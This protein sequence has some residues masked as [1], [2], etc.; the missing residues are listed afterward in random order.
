MA[1]IYCPLLLPGSCFLS[2]QG[3][4]RVC[5]GGAHLA[6]TDEFIY[7]R[8]QRRDGFSPV[9][10]STAGKAPGCNSFAGLVLLPLCCSCCFTPHPAADCGV[11]LKMTAKINRIVH[12]YKTARGYDVGGREEGG[13]EVRTSVSS[14][15]FV[16][17]AS[18]HRH[19]TAP[20]NHPLPHLL[21]CLQFPKL[22]S[23]TADPV[24][25]FLAVC[26]VSAPSRH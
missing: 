1:R 10:T 19:P 21:C 13:R 3:A 4:V 12:H 9:R 16:S 24:A 18:P 20:S 15:F 25:L 17:C 5:V 7:H 6:V 11:K 22:G 26:D 23:D 14:S 8:S 2:R